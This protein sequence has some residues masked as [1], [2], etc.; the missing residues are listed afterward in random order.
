[1]RLTA[2]AVRNAA[3][4]AKPQK[5]T[6]GRGLYL[7]V[8][9]AGGKLWRYD[10]RFDGKRKT[11]ALGQYPDVS[12]RVARERHAEARAQLAEG[13]DPGEARKI[14]R[15]RRAGISE[16][17]FEAVAREWFT[18]NKPRWAPG[19]AKRVLR[20]LEMDIFPWLGQDPI[21]EVAAPE[22]LATLRRVEA[23]G[24]PE[25]AHRELQVCGQVFRYAVAT[26]KAR[27]DPTR[28]LRGALTP[29]VSKHFATILDP[30]DIGALLRAIDGYKGAFATRCAL[31]VASYT[32][33]RPGELR[34]ADWDEIDLDTAAWKIPAEKMKMSR[35]HIVPLAHQ[36]VEILH[37]L[38]PVSGHGRYVFPS[39][40]GGSR[41]MSENTVNGALRRLGY[42]KREIT[43]HGFRSMASTLLHEQGWPSD[44]I[45]RQLA[46]VEGNSVKAAY[47]YAEHLAERRRMMQV[48]ADYLDGLKGAK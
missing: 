12:L 24:A 7:L 11:L 36:V 44:A 30:R 9:L 8:T 1:M 6:D 25:T 40:R 17:T 23:R 5:M 35:P 20:R 47:N 41:P 18:K 46:H 22:I 31:R 16:D 48:W 45:E 2:V 39:A 10:Y 33:V 21:S 19:H 3:P 42:E 37:D 38:R 34:H 14:G 13:V 26:G 27:R 28:D 15:A 32:F 29:V 43:G 4:R